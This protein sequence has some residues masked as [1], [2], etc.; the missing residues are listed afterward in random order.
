MKRLPIPELDVDEVYE[1]CVNGISDPVLVT[2]FMSALAQ[3]HTLAGE[4]PARTLA[5]QLHRYPV[6]QRGQTE[7]VVIDQLT[8]KQ[9]CELY[10]KQMVP[11]SKRA[12]KYYDK[13]LNSVPSAKCPLCGFGQVSTLDHFMPKS[14][15]PYFAV[16][17]LNLVPVCA[18]CNKKKVARMLRGC[19]QSSHPYFEEPQIETETWLYA[20]VVE[21]SPAT[22]KFSVLTPVAWPEKLSQRIKNHFADL[23]LAS[24]FAI[25]AACEI[26]SL[27]NSLEHFGTGKDIG[28][29]LRETAALEREHHKNT[30]K[31]ALYEGLSQSRWY[32]D[33]IH[34]RSIV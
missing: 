30:W 29:H 19:G 28:I 10:E 32:Q 20:E 34:R 33:R 13:L 4:Y 31:H 18:D 11:T 3:L 23:E 16:L 27:S 26:A 15:Y 17:P 24:R 2:G 14:F 12:R 9:F 25:E 22:A 7:Q 21:T 5:S 8:K 1:A 6:S